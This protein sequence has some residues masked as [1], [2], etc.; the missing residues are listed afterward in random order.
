MLIKIRL[1]TCPWLAETSNKKK[2]DLFKSPEIV[3]L[4]EISSQKNA[5]TNI[6][7][8]KSKKNLLCMVDLRRSHFRYN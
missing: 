6:D 2:R 4:G 3:A 7:Y 1:I 5:L 8:L